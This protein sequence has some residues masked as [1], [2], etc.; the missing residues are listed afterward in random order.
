M[1]SC[2]HYK[3]FKNTYFEKN[4]GTDASGMLQTVKKKSE[5]KAKI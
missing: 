2:E 3:T 5:K 4:V 1:F